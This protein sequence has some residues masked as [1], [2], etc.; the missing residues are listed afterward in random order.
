MARFNLR[1]PDTLRDRLDAAAR[2][3]R[4][5]KNHLAIFAIDYYLEEIEFWAEARQRLTS[6]EK[7][8]EHAEVL[9]TLNLS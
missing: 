1:V 6:N 2:Q 9:E 8:V 7:T 5:S 4:K 3:T